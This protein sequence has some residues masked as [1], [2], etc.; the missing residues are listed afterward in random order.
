MQNNQMKHV[1][2]GAWILSLSTL[3]AK[4][5]SAVYRVPFQNMVGDT[6]FYV[7]QQ[8]YPIY[9]LG[10]TF[11]LS[12]FPV[13]ISKVVAETDD[14]LEQKAVTRQSI[15]ILTWL[16]WV[17]FGLLQFGAQSIAN[18]MADPELVSLIQVVAY[19]FL[20]MPVL[21]SA[22]G[23]FQGTFDMVKTATSQ[24][25][26]QLVRVAVILVAAWLSLRERWSPY[27]MGAVA[28]GGAF[29]G[30]IVAILTLWRPY[31]RA[32]KGAP[33]ANASPMSYRTLGRRFLVEGGSIAMFS[34]MLF[35]LQLV[36]SFT[37]K[38]GLTAAGVLEPVAKSLKGIYD[39]GQPL[40]Q[41]GLVVATALATTLLPSMTSTLQRRR[42]GQFAQTG[43]ILIHLSLGVSTAATAGLII[44]MPA[45][46][47]LLFGDT[48]GTLAL[49]I[50][51]LSIIL[52]AMINAYNSV[53]QSLDQYRTTTIALAVGIVIKI[54]TNQ[55]LV[56]QYGTVGASASTVLS[57]GVIL[58]IVYLAVPSSVKM[59]GALR[60]FLPRLGASTLGMIALVAASVYW[61]PLTGRLSAITITILGVVVGVISFIVLATL[62]R[63]FTIREVLAIPAGRTFLKWLN[64][65]HNST[66]T[67]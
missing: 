14:P 13:F 25:T 58:N 50:Y 47:T 65:H 54:V 7:Y 37:V 10:M 9:G 16:S 27:Q 1:I 36:D 48:A 15:V 21:A 66:T 45:I 3:I 33:K 26:E 24:V 39:R 59:R 60:I 29:L 40:V 30:G 18:W 42:M 22:R 28:M 8:I 23:Y 67:H 55:A 17:I 2:R 12:G 52:V 4:I 31:A 51:C 44:L 6:G 56:M 32:F 34:A 35:F 46:N 19:M 20:T 43:G 63:V 62:F 38:R 61:L 49:Q 11:A 41:L 5:L 57:L 64:R 53:L